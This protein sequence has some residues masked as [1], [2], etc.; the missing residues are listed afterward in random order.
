MKLKRLSHFQRN[1]CSK[2]DRTTE[3]SRNEEKNC[4]NRRVLRLE[5]ESPR[6]WM[7][8]GTSPPFGSPPST[9]NRPGSDQ[10]Q[11]RTRPG[12]DKDQS[13]VRSGLDWER[14]G[15]DQSQSRISPWP[16]P[17]QTWTR[18]GSDQALIWV[19]AESDKDQSQITLGPNSPGLD[20]DQNRSRPTTDLDHS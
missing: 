11:T 3:K 14:V 17:D 18:P 2:N 19:K 1:V 10:E 8:G 15:T 5:G 9:R 6:F 16:N 12:L 7:L 4:F 13:Q 20:L